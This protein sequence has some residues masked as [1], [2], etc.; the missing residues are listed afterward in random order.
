[1]WKVIGTGR[2]FLPAIILRLTLEGRKAT[3]E[4]WGML[5]QAI[6]KL[7]ASLLLNSKR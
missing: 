6:P 1:M 5:Y 4:E 3:E 2:L 7:D